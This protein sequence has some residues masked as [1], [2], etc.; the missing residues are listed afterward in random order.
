[1][2]MLP[3]TTSIPH[4]FMYYFSQL[5]HPFPYYVFRVNLC[6]SSF[7][8]VSFSVNFLEC[9]LLFDSVF[10]LFCLIRYPCESKLLSWCTTIFQLKH[11][12]NKHMFVSVYSFLYFSCLAGAQFADCMVCLFHFEYSRSLRAYIHL[13]SHVLRF[14]DCTNIACFCQLPSRP[15][16]PESV[17]WI[18]IVSCM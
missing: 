18:F 1:M 6:L 7:Q 17:F 10:I 4:A 11:K 12:T 2:T 8:C 14:F 16:F 3:F 9:I 15:F 13:S 5:L